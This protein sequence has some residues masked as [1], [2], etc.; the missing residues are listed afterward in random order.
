M[1]VSENRCLPLLV[2]LQN[3]A[4]AYSFIPPAYS[5]QSLTD[6]VLSRLIFKGDPLF[7]TNYHRVTIP[8]IRSGKDSW[9]DSRSK[10]E[11]ES[12]VRTI[13]ELA[14]PQPRIW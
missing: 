3:Q 8:L 11:S 14:V 4:R 13:G 2:G 6:S 9:S 1:C 5:Y 12:V 10:P 7:C